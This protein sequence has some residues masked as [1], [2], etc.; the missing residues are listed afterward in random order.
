MEQPHHHPARVSL[1]PLPAALRPPHHDPR[2]ETAPPRDVITPPR[3]PRR[4]PHVLVVAL[5]E[6]LAEVGR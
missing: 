3:R 1:A 5:R 2:A 6:M 4:R